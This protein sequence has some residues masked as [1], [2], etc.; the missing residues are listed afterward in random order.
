MKVYVLLR[1][2]YEGDSTLVDDSFVAIA[3]KTQPLVLKA[4]D[5][6]NKAR[7]EWFPIDNGWRDEQAKKELAIPT[8]VLMPG[9][10]A[11]TINGSGYGDMHQ[12]FRI[13][14]TEL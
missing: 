14:E 1:C 8:R 7:D 10:D 12:V 13:I 4:C 3:I 6:A 5:E 2:W 9:E 11:A